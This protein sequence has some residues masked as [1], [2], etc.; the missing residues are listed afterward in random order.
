MT[1]FVEDKI[2]EKSFVPEKWIPCERL[3]NKI[4]LVKR[5]E[6]KMIVREKKNYYVIEKSNRELEK[7]KITR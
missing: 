3:K 5:K 4:G 2:T 7:E 6:T 1:I